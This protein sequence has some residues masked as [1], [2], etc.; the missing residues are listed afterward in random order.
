ML[1]LFHVNAGRSK[2]VGWDSAL[3]AEWARALEGK[4]FNKNWKIALIIDNCPAH[5]T[6]DNLSNLRLI[7]LPP[8]TSLSAYGSKVH[9]V[10]EN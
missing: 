7:F 2:K 10:L 8:N 6:I 5:P 3:F 1:N 4:F 9:K